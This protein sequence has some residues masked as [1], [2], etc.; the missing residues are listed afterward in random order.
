MAA[1]AGRGGGKDPKG[2]YETLGVGLQADEAEIR[3]AYRRL[4]L[5]WHPDKNPEDPQA[6]AMFQGISGA[7]EVLSDPERRKMYDTTGCIDAEELDEAGD[8]DHA[9]DLFAAFFGGA[10]S[11][12]LDA[13][14]Q[15]MLDEFLRIAG[16]GAF[17]RRGRGRARRGRGGRGGGG[18]RSSRA[19]RAQE[20]QLLGEM[21]MAAM[22]GGLAG[23]PPEP[24][25]AC[26]QGHAL[27]KR[28]AET[29]Y[30]CDGCGATIAEGRRML[31]CRKCDFSLCQ[32]CQKAA[33]QQAAAQEGEEGE[34]REVLEA[35]CEM[36]IT[37]VRRGRQLHF[38]CD[39]CE[40]LLETQAEAAAH[41]EREHEEEIRAIM[42]EAAREGGGPGPF[43]AGGLEELFMAATLGDL[44]G[45]PGGPPRAGG[46]AA[47]G[48]GGKKSRKRR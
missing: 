4:A 29:T 10:G 43:G 22:A 1:A 2:L 21:L 44:L 33:E 14:E 38:R 32:K 11:A 34:Y 9:A 35:M 27:K 17:R 23:G 37:P 24:T 20:E 41:I 16:G 46:P 25:L 42:E 13:E 47:G 15:A 7:Y 19:S 8:L 45:G 36:S 30:A 5:R 6:T 40:A 31:D 39:L 3:K 48:P 26:P 18:P 28:K 12:D